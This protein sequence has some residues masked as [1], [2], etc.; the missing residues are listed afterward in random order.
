MPI[1]YY[2]AESDC[3]FVEQYE[4]I[5]W[6]MVTECADVSCEPWAV[7]RYNRE[8][9]GYP[10]HLWADREDGLAHCLTCGAGECELTTDC[11]GHRT[12]PARREEVCAGRLDYWSG[13][14]L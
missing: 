6:S 5:D 2:H 3:L 11:P 10:V 7:E 12:S 4:V 1:L 8:V 13:V 14:W 9:P